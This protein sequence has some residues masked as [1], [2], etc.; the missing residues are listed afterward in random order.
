MSVLNASSGCIVNEVVI[1]WKD[2][3]YSFSGLS[4]LQHSKIKKTS[5][6]LG[7]SVVL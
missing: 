5:T 7:S 4:E 3:F 6:D 2:C 1:F